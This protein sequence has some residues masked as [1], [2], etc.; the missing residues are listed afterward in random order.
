[1][2]RWELLELHGNKHTNMGVYP[3]TAAHGWIHT[4]QMGLDLYTHCQPAMNGA[5]TQT[6]SSIWTLQ[7]DHGDASSVHVDGRGSS[8]LHRTLIGAF[9]AFPRP[10]A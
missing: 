9:R 7:Q 3:H 5:H 2:C 1:M 8:S 6:Q 4:G 10:S